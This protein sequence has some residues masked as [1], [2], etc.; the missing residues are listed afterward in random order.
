MALRPCLR[1]SRLSPHSYCPRCGG[2]PGRTGAPI[3]VADQRTFR[4]RTLAQSGG[5][6]ARCGARGVPLE[7]HHLHELSGGG[8]PLGEGVALCIPC[9]QELRRE[10]FATMSAS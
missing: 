2:R 5:R 10:S 7:A 4:K 1:C 3:S 9:H 6:C 8:A